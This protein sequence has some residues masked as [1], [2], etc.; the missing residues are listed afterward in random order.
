MCQRP[1]IPALSRD[2]LKNKNC[3]SS[4]QWQN[5]QSNLLTHPLIFLYIIDKRIVHDLVSS[6]S[7]IIA[8]EIPVTFMVW[9]C[10]M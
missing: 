7:R 10:L 6:R 3:G 5:A 9:T 8:C 2:L 1:V 4:P